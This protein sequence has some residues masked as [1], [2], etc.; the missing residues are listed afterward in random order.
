MVMAMNE[1]SHSI[2]W[3]QFE[4]AAAQA[5]K[6]GNFVQA[7][8][9]LKE[10]LREAEEYCEITPNLITAAHSLAE[11]HLAQHRYKEAEALYRLVLEVREKLLG[12]THQDVVDSLKKVAIVQI[13][14]FRAEALGRRSAEPVLSF[15][16]MMAIA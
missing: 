13:M 10:A 1:N 3:E 16:D 15:D 4:Q 5:K 2:L 14:S 6:Q 8:R 12:P 9:I 7:A 11:L